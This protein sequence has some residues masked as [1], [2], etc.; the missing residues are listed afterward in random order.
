MLVVRRCRDIAI[1][2]CVKDD[3]LHNKFYTDVRFLFP[4][5]RMERP[6]THRSGKSG[7]ALQ[8]NYSVQHRSD[9]LIEEQVNGI[10]VQ[11]YRLYKTIHM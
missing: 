2:L 9:I 8:S 10:S 4:A 1:Q 5:L 11:M 6:L 3:L 7:L